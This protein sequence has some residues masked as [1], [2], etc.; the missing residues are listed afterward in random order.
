MLL[1]E[2]LKNDITATLVSLKNG[3]ILENNI[4][5][6]LDSLDARVNAEARAI[7]VEREKKEK[8]MKKLNDLAHL[9]NTRMF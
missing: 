6:D 5:V 9:F 2:N 3:K 1:N 8:Q 4:N 7:E